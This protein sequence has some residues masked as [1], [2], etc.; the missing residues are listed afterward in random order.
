M[1]N[2]CR[3]DDSRGGIRQCANM[4]C[5]KWERYPREFAK[6]RRCRKA[7]YCGKECQSK[8]WSDGHRF[9]CSVKEGAP[10][11]SGAVNASGE[12][13][14]RNEGDTAS[15]A[16][17]RPPGTRRREGG[18][19]TRGGLHHPT[20]IQG[21]R[22]HGVNAAAIQQARQQAQAHA[23]AH[24]ERTDPFVDAPGTR[25]TPLPPGTVAFTTPT[26][27]R[28]TV[29]VRMRP[30][31]TIV[32]R[33]VEDAPTRTT[34]AAV[35]NHNIAPPAPTTPTAPVPIPATGD[36]MVV[37]TLP[38]PDVDM[39]FSPPIP[40]NDIFSRDV[41]PDSFVRP[42]PRRRGPQA[43]VAGPSRSRQTTRT[44]AQTGRDVSASSSRSSA[45]DVDM[46]MG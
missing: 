41:D 8:A 17:V 13:G 32:E 5:G 6:C 11:A 40:A 39:S 45:M 28:H 23:Q 18:P 37:G 1:R 20:V 26:T 35:A 44:G 24:R 2:A 22:L 33:A 25:G 36:M 27:G 15:V 34:T 10:N 14:E 46:E 16:T 9:W 12:R 43:P 29:V 19:A 4:I 7:R 31:G 38:D 3:K 30:D 42:V 21:G